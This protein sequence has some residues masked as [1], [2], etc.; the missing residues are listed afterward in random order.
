MTEENKKVNI[1][2]PG[3]ISLMGELTDW[4]CEYKFENKNIVVGRAIATTIDKGIYITANKYNH[5]KFHM[6][7]YDFECPMI[8][9]ELSTNA[10]S[11]S[12]YAYISG[13]ALHMFRKYN[14]GGINFVVNYSTLPIKKGLASSAAI[15]SATV[16]AFNELYNLNLSE[17]EM[18]NDAYYGERLTQSECGRLDQIVINKK[19]C[20]YE[21]IFN[22]NCISKK[23]IKVKNEMNLVIV[24]LMGHKNT[25]KILSSLRKCYPFAKN[26]KKKAVQELFGTDNLTMINKTKKAIE[27]GNLET[28]G[29]LFS[30]SQAAIDR[31]C[32]PICDEYKAP[33]LHKVINDEYI[34][35]MSYGVRGIGSGGDGSAQILATSR[36]NQDK[37][38]NY[39]INKLKMNAFKY[40]IKKSHKIKKAIIPVAGLGSRMYPITRAINKA[41]IPINDAG[42][43]KPLILKLVE[44]LDAVG[45][46]EI[47]L[48]LGKGMES[49]YDKL[50][51]M[52]LNEKQLEN[53]SPSEL[54]YDMN[55]LRIGSKIKYV[56]QEEPLGFGHAVYLC[57]N[58]IKNEPTLVVLGD[59]YYQTDNECSCIEQ[60]INYYDEVEKNIVSV[61]EVNDEQISTVGVISGCFL[62]K[63]HTKIKINNMVEKPKLEYAK[64]HLK[65]D[66]KYYGNFGIWAID[67]QVFDQIEANISNANF[68]K[69][70]YEFVDALAQIVDKVEVNAICVDG[71]SYDIGNI[72]SYKTA[73]RST[74]NEEI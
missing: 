40:N 6:N 71:K 51:K 27:E 13:A 36:E 26:S 61:Q 65:L 53:M 69:V 59:T 43:I 17:E 32:T 15:C 42:N 73:L 30:E 33:L 19:E 58:F 72:K 39:C 3:R 5:L 25:K 2:I 41:F 67:H 24:D 8:E 35:K 64:K 60:V 49:Q 22:E 70:E 56:I 34:K 31:V 16:R 57:K 12:F 48:V 20:L 63:E 38:V 4:T 23:S 28:V 1:F 54:D 9:Q 66:G 68:N 37:I 45:I 10:S 52:P 44:D 50:F 55:I 14:V 21:I 74:F 18:M 11:N 47:F 7:D 62:D 46:E 29:K